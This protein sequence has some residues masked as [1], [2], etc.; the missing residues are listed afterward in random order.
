MGKIIAIAN[1]KGGVGK[2]TTCLEI[3]AIL[4]AE[5]KKKVLV[6]DFDQQLSTTK[7]YGLKQENT[8]MN[9]FNEEC[10]IKD[11][12]QHTKYFDAI[13]GDEGMSKADKVYDGR[14]DIYL[15]ADVC[16]VLKNVY[17]Y[18]LIDNS[19]ARNVCLNMAYCAADY[20]VIPV[21]ATPDSIRGLV[22]VQNDVEKL[23]NTR[24]KASHAEIIA[25]I[26]VAYEKS[27]VNEFTLEKLEEIAEKMPNDVLIEKTRKSVKAK[28]AKYGNTTLYEY[29]KYSNPVLDYKRIVAKLIERIGE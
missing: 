12:I 17:D 27:Q 16:D 8:I 11:G 22:S 18:I 14:D 4:G 28:E 2:T 23:R 9:I 24:E 20:I 21:D 15:L 1:Q 13:P 10:K 26:L 5:Q 19:P 7:N 3:A 6:I 25:F 29:A